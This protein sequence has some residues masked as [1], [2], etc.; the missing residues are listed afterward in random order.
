MHHSIDIYKGGV[1]KSPAYSLD[2]DCIDDLATIRSSS[3]G[4][5]YL[6]DPRFD[7]VVVII[8]VAGVAGIA[9]MVFWD[10]RKRKARAAPQVP[11]LPGTP[12]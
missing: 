5:Y 8:V 4:K 10:R 9:A 3:Y 11:P 12:P 7:A 2:Q 6:K 1:P